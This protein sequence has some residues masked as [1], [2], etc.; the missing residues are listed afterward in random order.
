MVVKMRYLFISLFMS[1]IAAC[2]GG[3]SS[4]ENSESSNNDTSNSGVVVVKASLSVTTA[5]VGEKVVVTYDLRD[6]SS[7]TKK[8]A[9]TIHWG[10]VT[11]ERVSGRG[12]VSHS[13][14]EAGEYSV[15]LRIDDGS[16]KKLGKVTI[17]ANTCRSRVFIPTSNSSG[18]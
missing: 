17:N 1:L 9:G 13:Y 5:N 8:I 11:G 12:T 16:V 4:S 10:D 7:K 2:G 14:T 3:N 18:C 6:G 15:N